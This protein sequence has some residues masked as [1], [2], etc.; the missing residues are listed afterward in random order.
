MRVI[1]PQATGFQLAELAA[2]ISKRA[3]SLG[4]VQL[5]FPLYIHD[6]SLNN[7]F[8]KDFEVEKRFWARPASAQ[9]GSY[10]NWP[11][12]TAGIAPGMNR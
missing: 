7:V 5:G 1:S 10:T 11:L 8:N 3:E 9:Y 12:G 6:I 4:G 2:A